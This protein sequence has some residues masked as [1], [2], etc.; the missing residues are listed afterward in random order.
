MNQTEKDL[1]RI[2]KRYIH[3]SKNSEDKPLEF[4]F[5]TNITKPKPEPE[6][7]NIVRISNK[8]MITKTTQNIKNEF[9]IDK[10]SRALELPGSQTLSKFVTFVSYSPKGYI[11]LKVKDTK[12]RRNQGAW[13]EQKSPKLKM[14]ILNEIIGKKYLFK[15][16]K[17]R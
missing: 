4:Y 3:S 13:F 6:I 5:T 8:I 1:L 15:N 2:F 11:E 16:D 7:F 14:P 9:G 12:A 10:V 17:S